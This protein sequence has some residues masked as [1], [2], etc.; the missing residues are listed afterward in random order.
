VGDGTWAE[1]SLVVDGRA[2]PVVSAG[3]WDD[4]GEFRA[5]LRLIETP[6]RLLVHGRR[7]GS[8]HLGWHEVPL[9]GPDPLT[10]AVHP[11]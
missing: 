3:G 2:L 9:H 5:E 10:L 6:H 4:H 11:G 8:A 7:D 1:S